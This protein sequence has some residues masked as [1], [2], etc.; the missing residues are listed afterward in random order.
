MPYNFKPTPKAAFLTTKDGILRE[1]EITKR[2]IKSFGK[3]AW[4]NIKSNI[5]SL[6]KLVYLRRLLE[7]QN[8]DELVWLLLSN[9][10]HKREKLEYHYPDGTPNRLM[11]EDEI[12]QAIEKIRSKY[13]E[14]FDY[15]TEYKKT[16]DVQILRELYKK[17]E[18]NYEKL[19]IY[20][21]LFN[22]NNSTFPADISE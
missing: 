19:Q 21:I 7:I 15:D 13:I 4:E 18:S 9:I 6:I 3:I 16:Q 11:T 17:S 8:E 22:E 14:D 1:K 12:E 20:R 5:D 10:F 2:N